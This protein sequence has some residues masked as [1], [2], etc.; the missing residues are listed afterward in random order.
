[1]IEHVE[2]LRTAHEAARLEIESLHARVQ[3]LEQE[4]QDYQHQFQ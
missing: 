3:E 2:T 1:M 4:A